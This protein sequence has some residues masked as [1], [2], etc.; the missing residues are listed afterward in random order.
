MLHRE[1]KKLLHKLIQQHLLFRIIE[2]FE[3]KLNKKIL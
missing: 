2:K 1:I 3:N